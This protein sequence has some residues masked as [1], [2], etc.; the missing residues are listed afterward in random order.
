MESVIKTA[1]KKGFDEIAFTDHF[2][3]SL[4]RHPIPWERSFNEYFETINN[5]KE[6]YKNAI[7]LTTGAEVGSL[8]QIARET[9]NFLADK[10]FE[11]TLLSVHMIEDY[12][13]Y[14]DDFYEDKTRR[15]AFETYFDAVYKLLGLVNNF[16]VF[17]HLD[18]PRRYYHY[19]ETEFHYAEHADILDA[20][21]KL[22]I[23]KNRGLE[24]NTAG[25][26]YAF[27]ECHPA[28]AILRRYK[29][30]GGEI[31]TIGSDAH[32]KE[33]VGRYFNESLEVAKKAGF[34]YLTRFLDKKPIFVPID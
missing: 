27:R 24:I 3:F 18:L 16:S 11:F 17:G 2:E 4:K 29:E 28:L 33:S 13:L 20:I 34:K 25:F 5:F 21:L 19:K 31:L 8:W 15:K 1:I 22:I 14:M 6:K 9:E 7:K 10:D 12:E 23:S 32:S 30:F 26:R